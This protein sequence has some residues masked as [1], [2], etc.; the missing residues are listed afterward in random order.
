MTFLKK[1]S[2][3]KSMI[4]NENDERSFYFCES[5]DW[6]SVVLA[7]SNSEAAGNALKQANEFYGENLNV[8]PCIRI[9]KIQ[10]EFEDK[11]VLFRIEQVFADI[12]MHKESKNI[13][14][15]LKNI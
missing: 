11:D 14:K 6:S 10:L 1:S 4:K 13:S 3:Y 15:I 5:A 12:G 9:K 7:K 8:S 2:R